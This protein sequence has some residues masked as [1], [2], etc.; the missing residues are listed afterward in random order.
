MNISYV[1]YALDFVGL[2]MVSVDIALCV[3]GRMIKL[4]WTPMGAPVDF[5]LIQLRKSHLTISFLEPQFSVSALRAAIW[6]VSFVK[7]MTFQK[8]AIKMH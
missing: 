7:I 8:A 1:N 2:K 4:C 3:K 5:A 6:H